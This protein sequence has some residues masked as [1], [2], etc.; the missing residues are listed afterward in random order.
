MKN[1]SI[2]H[3]IKPKDKRHS[4]NPA[5]KQGEGSK[6]E[7]LVHFCLSDDHREERVKMHRGEPSR[8]YPDLMSALIFWFL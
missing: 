6:G 7:G 8:F 5:L 1:S 2:S 4:G 3:K